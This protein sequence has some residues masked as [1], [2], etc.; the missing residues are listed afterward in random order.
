MPSMFDWP[1][2]MNTCTG[3]AVTMQ[4]RAANAIAKSMVA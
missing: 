3:E 2:R 4:S 1:R